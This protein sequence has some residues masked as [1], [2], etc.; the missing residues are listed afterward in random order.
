MRRLPVP[1][2]THLRVHNQV[3]NLLYPFHSLISWHGRPTGDDCCIAIEQNQLKFLQ[4]QLPELSKGGQLL[5]LA[6]PRKARLRVP[7]RVV[8]SA[9]L[10]VYS[11]PTYAA[12]LTERG[13][14][15]AISP[16]AT[17]AR[18]VYLQKA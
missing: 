10:D 14:R 6:F 17:E 12:Q 1:L 2:W 7:Y 3:S 8:R 18:V 15:Y 13:R 4:L 16:K 9:E 5:L 11:K